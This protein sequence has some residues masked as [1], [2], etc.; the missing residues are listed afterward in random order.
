MF[1]LPAV[2]GHTVKVWPKPKSKVR[3]T[4]PLKL[5]LSVLFCFFVLFSSVLGFVFILIDSVRQEWWS[6]NVWLSHIWTKLLLISFSWDSQIWNYSIVWQWDSEDDWFK[7]CKIR[8]ETPENQE[9]SVWTDDWVLY[10]DFSW[11]K[12]EYIPPPLA[13]WG[14]LAPAFMLPLVFPYVDIR[15]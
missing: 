11:N 12:Y 5:S 2:Y 4:L 6:V 3:K 10:G 7:H 1:Q 13:C 15:K 9:L 8:V 14:T